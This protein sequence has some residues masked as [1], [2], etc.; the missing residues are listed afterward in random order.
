VTVVAARRVTGLICLLRDCE[1]P[2]A[3]REFCEH[4]LLV[5]QQE[6]ERLR[7]RLLEQTRSQARLALQPPGTSSTATSGSES[8]IPDALLKAQ[9]QIAEQTNADYRIQLEE[10]SKFFKTSMQEYRAVVQDALGWKCDSVTA[11]ACGG[12]CT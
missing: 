6:N 2:H 8:G 9:L 4:Q 3:C 1:L 5:I 7:G 12:I 11:P 10:L